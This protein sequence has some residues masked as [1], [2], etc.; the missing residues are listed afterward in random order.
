NRPL[1]EGAEFDDGE[2]GKHN[3]GQE[4]G[5]PYGKSQRHPQGQPK[6][7]PPIRIDTLGRRNAR[8]MGDAGSVYES[9]A[10]AGH[11]M[12][13]VFHRLTLVGMGVYGQVEHFVRVERK[14]GGLEKLHARLVR[15]AVDQR[16]IWRH[17]NEL[18]RLGFSAAL[19]KVDSLPEVGG[20]KLTVNTP[21]IQ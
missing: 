17:E 8:I 20:A 14:V 3:V 4:A 7:G 2:Q 19:R 16:R 10:P 13:R 1:P 21:E 18:V 6:T 9:P 5:R 15:L 12:R 11:N